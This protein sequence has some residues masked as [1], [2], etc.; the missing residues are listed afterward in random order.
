MK[1]SFESNLIKI[2]AKE[3]VDELYG[4]PLTK[5]DRDMAEFRK[6]NIQKPEKMKNQEYFEQIENWQ[7]FYQETFKIT[8]NFSKLEIPEK[9]EG[10]DKLII[11]A[12]SMT[13]QKIFD[14]C[15]EFFPAKKEKIND[16]YEIEDDDLDEITISDRNAKKESYAIWI[17]DRV[18]AD[19]ELKNLS[20]R[21]IKKQGLITETL[22][23]RLIQELE[24]FSRTKKHLEGKITSTFCAGS[25]FPI[26]FGDV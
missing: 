20:F 3:V 17:R 9:R 1:N 2:P 13:P 21:D 12:K 7:N 22:E 10:F 19:E 8:P 11:I 6:K 5:G 14:K 4:A 15:Q 25:Q 26:F 18:E 24:Y 23:E 16:N